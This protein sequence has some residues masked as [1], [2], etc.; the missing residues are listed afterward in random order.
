MLNMMTA[1]RA[2]LLMPGRHID[3]LPKQIAEEEDGGYCEHAQPHSLQQSRCVVCSRGPPLETQQ[4][5]GVSSLY[6]S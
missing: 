4:I 5:M 3:A 6:F 1:T 2:H